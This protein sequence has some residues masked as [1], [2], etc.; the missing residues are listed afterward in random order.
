MHLNFAD[1]LISPLTIRK[2]VAEPS[3]HFARNHDCTGV[4]GTLRGRDRDCARCTT[5]IARGRAGRLWRG[6]GRGVVLHPVRDA[7]TRQEATP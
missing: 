6:V 1:G 3:R 5:A 4:R 2:L 7:S